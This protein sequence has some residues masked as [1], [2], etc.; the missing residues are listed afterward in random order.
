MFGVDDAVLIPAIISALG[1]MASAAGKSKQAQTTQ[2][3][4]SSPGQIADMDKARQIGMQGLQ[5]PYEGFQPIADDAQRNFMSD[6]LP[7]IAEQFAGLG[8]TRSSGYQ[9]MMSGAGE[10]LQSKLAAMKSQYGMQ[11][12]NSMMN[13]MQMGMRPQF[14]NIYQPES[15]G[16]MQMLGDSAMGGGLGSLMSIMGGKYLGDRKAKQRSDAIKQYQDARE[17][18]KSRG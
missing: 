4:T 10:G 3:P 14:G 6:T 15:A 12:R 16:R 7:R 11:N 17:A 8:G 1:A 2:L 5:N 13:L 9:G 18:A